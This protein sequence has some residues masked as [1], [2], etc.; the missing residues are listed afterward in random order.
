MLDRHGKAGRLRLLVRE[1]GAAF[2]LTMSVLRSWPEAS[3][4]APP[5]IVRTARLDLSDFDER[6]R[7]AATTVLTVP[8]HAANEGLV[9]V[10]IEQPERGRLN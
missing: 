4:E 3:F 9:D 7:V 5:A 2:L 6:E 1:C 10:V 8:L